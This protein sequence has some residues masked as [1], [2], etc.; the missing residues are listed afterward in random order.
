MHVLGSR[1]RKPYYTGSQTPFRARDARPVPGT[2]NSSVSSWAVETISIDTILRD[3]PE[4]S[5]SSIS[6][7]LIPCSL[8]RQ[9]IRGPSFPHALSGNLGESGSGP[10]IKT[11]GGDEVRTNWREG[12]SIPRCLRRGLHSHRGLEFLFDKSLSTFAVNH[13]FL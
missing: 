10:P 13:T 4:M 8:L 3:L 5:C 1:K 6:A 12:L 2:D 11:F 9:T 7:G